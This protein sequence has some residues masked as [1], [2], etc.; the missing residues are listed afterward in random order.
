MSQRTCRAYS[1]SMRVKSQTIRPQSR[2]RWNKCRGVRESLDS[3]EPRDSNEIAPPSGDWLV[4]V[5]GVTHANVQEI[6]KILEAILPEASFRLTVDER[7]NQLIVTSASEA[8]MESIETL[9]ST[10]DVQDPPLPMSQSPGSGADPLQNPYLN[11]ATPSGAQRVPMLPGQ[12]MQSTGLADDDFDRML[13]LGTREL[14][15]DM[16][17]LRKDYDSMEE[18]S[19]AIAA[20]LRHFEDSS[21]ARDEQLRQLREAV[22]Q[23]FEARQKLQQAELIDFSRR[24][25]T[26]R[27]SLEARQTHAEEIIERRVQ[28]LQNPELQWNNRT[29]PVVLDNKNGSPIGLPGPVDIPAP[30]Y[31]PLGPSSGITPPTEPRPVSI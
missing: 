10:L 23:A 13:L 25:K 19:Q 5:F 30:V 24:L 28:E 14:R 7:T 17:K 3:N 26:I 20:S 22:R 16:K 1:A 6:A 18:R 21:K 15:L 8:I 2:T 12:E 29:D 9:V 31:I 11:D 4:K 27:D